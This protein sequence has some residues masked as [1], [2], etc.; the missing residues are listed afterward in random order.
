MQ[1]TLNLGGTANFR[2]IR[3]KNNGMDQSF[4]IFKKEEIIC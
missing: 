1:L 3:P 2:L 4:F